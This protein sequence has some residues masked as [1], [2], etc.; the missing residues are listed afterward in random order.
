M[1]LFI[2]CPFQ[3][4]SLK[5]IYAS[6][7]ILNKIQFYSSASQDQWKSNVHCVHSVK[8]FT[9]AHLICHLVTNSVMP[10]IIRQL[11]WITLASPHLCIA[12][13]CFRGEYNALCLCWKCDK[14]A[15][16]A[17]SCASLSAWCAH[18]SGSAA[19]D[20]EAIH[21]VVRCCQLGICSD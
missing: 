21:P 16:C 13:F 8:T 3:T 7:T 6:A 15:H 11:I 2:R 18:S 20:K 14:E 19:L 4:W 5:A 10:H 1:F 12:V 9:N 17:V